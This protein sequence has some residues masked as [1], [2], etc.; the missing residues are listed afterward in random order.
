[1]IATIH[2]PNLFPRLKIL[3]KIALSD[4]WIVLDNVQFAKRE[5]QNRTL[6]VPNHEQQNPFWCTI[7]VHLSNGRNTKINE[8]EVDVEKFLNKFE[9]IINRSFKMSDLK[10]RNFYKILDDLSHSNGNLVDICVTSTVT[11]LQL[12]ECCPKI[13]YAS[14]L[15]IC[16]IGKNERLAELCTKIGADTYLS[17]SGGARYVNENIFNERN[18]NVLWHVWRNYT[19][20]YSKLSRE[21]L[22]N[23]SGINLLVRSKQEFIDVVS[24]CIVTKKKIHTEETDKY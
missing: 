24:S 11:L 17:D 12:V 23:S 10:R 14:E 22:R 6:I 2:Q 21:H 8:I 4:V 3:Q 16:E 1:M 5:Y 20:K 9:K 7:P 13:I 15:N 18:I 19:K